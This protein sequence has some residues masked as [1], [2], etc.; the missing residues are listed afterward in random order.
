MKA[1]IV[2][3]RSLFY[4][5]DKIDLRG[6]DKYIAFS[7]LSIYYKWK[8]LRKSYKNNKFTTSAPTCNEEFELTVGS[9]FISDIQDYVEYILKNMEKRLL[10]LQYEYT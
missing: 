8:N 4:R 3:T 2:K 9:Y 5:I 6:K 1:E 10:I 7:N